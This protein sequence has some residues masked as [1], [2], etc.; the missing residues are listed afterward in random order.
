MSFAVDFDTLGISGRPGRAA[1]AL[2]RPGAAVEAFDPSFRSRIMPTMN[3]SN[4]LARQPS[5][6]PMPMPFGWF[7][8][9][10]SDEL[11]V[12]QSRAL[13]YFDA[14]LVLY[15]GH[16]GKAVVLDAYCPH[17]GAHLGHGIHEKAGGGGGR[18]DGD[19]IICPF[20]AWRFNERGECVEVP[21]ADKMP[22][23]VAGKA[24]LKSWP[25]REANG[26]IYVWYHPHGAEPLWEL[27]KYE[28]PDS[29]E[30]GVQDR[31]EWTIKT[32]PQE[33]AE[34]G[35]DPAHF[36]YVHRVANMPTWN[37]EYEG[38]LALARQEAKM[39]T[40]RGTVNGAI[41]SRT[42]GPGQGHVR[43]TG[44]CETFQLGLTTPVDNDYVHVRFAFMQR[45]EDEAERAGVA[46]AL[47]RDICRQMGED[48][49]VWEHKKFHQKPTLCDG[50]GPIAKFR[51]WYSQ[52]YAEPPAQ[53]AQA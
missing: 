22:P 15:R 48:K 6:Y 3:S 33:M 52:F 36:L 23:K 51:K 12:G 20:H 10:Y 29:G 28:E 47:K 42:C 18:I 8:V 38:R 4:V 9:S 21:Y 31:F 26:L 5:R 43:Y 50:D 19:T 11:E 7:V 44:I 49:I 1:F 17:L 32:H 16:S 53:A 41:T 46:R 2:P 34:N 30:W 14:D 39:K 45:K 37:I 40:P 35:A 13:R 25:A 27:E 24:C